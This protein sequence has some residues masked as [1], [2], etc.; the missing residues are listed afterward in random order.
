M[1]NKRKIPP[2]PVAKIV[3]GAIVIPWVKRK[4]L[5]YGLTVTGGAILVLQGIAYMLHTIEPKPGWVTAANWIGALIYFVLFVKF[6]VLCHRIV[7]LGYDSVKDAL[8]PTDWSKRETAFMLRCIGVY[9]TFAVV[10]FAVITLPSGIIFGMGD[11][12]VGEENSIKLFKVFMTLA[13]LPG[14]YLFA[15][16]SLLFPAAALDNYQNPGWAWELSKDNGLRL[17]ITVGIVPWILWWLW[18]YVGSDSPSLLESVVLLLFNMVLWVI[19]IA[20]LSLSYKELMLING[21]I[22]EVGVI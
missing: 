8:L 14:A 15:R 20:A 10:Y 13:A 2:L 7:L 4:E 17:A 11:F 18:S 6:A 1:E 22:E 5:L 21:K 19:E 3:L 12:I 16:L 9:L